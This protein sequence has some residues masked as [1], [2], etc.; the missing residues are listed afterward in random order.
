GA[1]F[2]EGITVKNV[3]QITTQPK[4]GEIQRKCQQFSSWGGSGFPGA[5]PVSM[6][7]KNIKF[8]EQKTYKV[9]WKADG[10]R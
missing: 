3:T 5:Q 4:L 10:T 2:L 6:D 8:L 1:V 7:R 9:S